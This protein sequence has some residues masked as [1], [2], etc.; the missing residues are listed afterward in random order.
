MNFSGKKSL[1]ILGMKKLCWQTDVGNKI[2]LSNSLKIV[3][4]NTQDGNAVCDLLSDT[5]ANL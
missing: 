5:M 1:P 3:D 4:E 2:M